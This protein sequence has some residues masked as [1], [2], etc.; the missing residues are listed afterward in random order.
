MPTAST[1]LVSKKVTTKALPKSAPRTQTQAQRQQAIEAVAQ[2]LVKFGLA[3]SGIRTW[4]KAAG[5][6]DR[7]LIYHFQSKAQLF[8][9]CLLHLALQLRTELTAQLSTRRKLPAK[10]LLQALSTQMQTPSRLAVARLFF[11]VVLLGS[12][13]GEPDATTEKIIAKKLSKQ[14]A[15]A[16]LEWIEALLEPAQKASARAE[17]LEL[18]AEIE[19]RL[20]LRFAGFPSLV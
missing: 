5:L 11:E 20:L 6:S 1:R 4:A 16:Y 14:I 9:A 10:D 7:M 17:A 3:D 15:S 13:A 12:H 8:E 19:G 18:F 2:H